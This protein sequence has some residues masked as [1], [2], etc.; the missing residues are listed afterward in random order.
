MKKAVRLFI[1]GSMQ[2][3]FFKNFIKDAADG[4]KLT[5]FMR[6]REDGKVEIFVQGESEAVNSMIELCKVGPKYAKIR[7]VEQIDERMQDFKEF[8]VLSF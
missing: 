2:S 7:N 5:G 3:M 8:K 1:T 4:R 6:N